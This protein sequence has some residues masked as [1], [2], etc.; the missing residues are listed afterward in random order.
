ML[1]SIRSFVAS[2]LVVALLSGISTAFAAEQNRTYLIERFQDGDIP[3]GQDFADL[4]DSALNLVDDGLTTYRIG[5]DSSGAALR[6]NAG[7]TVSPLL[8]FIPKSAN[9]PM[10]PLWAG[11]FGF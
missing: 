3:T 1:K 2:F 8:T 10:A 4:I 11:E 5:V 6:L 7:E 9:P